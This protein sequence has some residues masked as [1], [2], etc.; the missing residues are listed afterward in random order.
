[1]TD[2][3]WLLQGRAEVSEV[4][5]IIKK[6]KTKKETPNYI[7]NMLVAKSALIKIKPDNVIRKEG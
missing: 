5:K 7:N 3:K 1:M 6:T 4:G 2:K